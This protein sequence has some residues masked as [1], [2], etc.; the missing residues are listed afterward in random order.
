MNL[1]KRIKVY[2]DSLYF[3]VYNLYFCRKAFKFQKLILKKRIK[4]NQ[5]NIQNYKEVRKNFPMLIE[6]LTLET[7]MIQQVLCKIS[8]N[9]SHLDTL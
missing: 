8:K 7:E 1:A 6:N 9:I 3:I 2:S 4:Y 5:I